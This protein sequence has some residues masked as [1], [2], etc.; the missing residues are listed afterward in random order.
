[1]THPNQI[2][3]V[4]AKLWA[5]EPGKK[6]SHVDRNGGNSPDPDKEM[7]GV[8]VILDGVVSPSIVEQPCYLGPL[9][10]QTGVGLN[11]DVILL[12]GERTVVD[13]G[14]EL[15]EPTEP[16]RFSSSA[17]DGLADFSPIFAAMV[18]YQPR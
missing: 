14:G 6:A 18:M 17:L 5:R 13:F 16:T 10:P 9:T 3:G 1:M 2:Q 15:V 7:G 12:G 8:P 11:D 4:K